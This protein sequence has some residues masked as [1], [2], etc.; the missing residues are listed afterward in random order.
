MPHFL[1]FAYGSNLLAARLRARCPSAAF[2]GAASLADHVLAC[3]VTARDGSTKFA[4]RPAPGGLGFGA[5][6]RIDEVDRPSLAAVEGVNYAETRG[7]LVV[8][9]EGRRIDVD[10]WLPKRRPELGRPWDWY[11]DLALAGARECRLPERAI[12]LVAATDADV[13]PLRDRP[14][15]REAL[16]ALAAPRRV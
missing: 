15:C 2:V 14:G 12:A 1:Y 10:T 7:V 9:G 13:D 8:D 6:W 4:L 3:D 5:V 16:A 11:R